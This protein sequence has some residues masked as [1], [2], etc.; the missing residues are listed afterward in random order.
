MPPRSRQAAAPAPPAVPEPSA[1]EKNEEEK[2]TQA[3]G[4]VMQ[5][6]M[7]NTQQQ[8][9]N[10]ILAAV[11][12]GMVAGLLGCEGLSGLVIFA[13]ITLASSALTVFSLGFQ[14]E[15]Y[16]VSWSAALF[17]NFAAG[18]MTFMLFWILAYDIVHVF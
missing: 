7:S 14:V 5:N 6:V 18:L 4:I 17:G 16:F 10:R 15:K 8:Y 1:A 13:A 9:S 11:V 2:A 12:A 3:A